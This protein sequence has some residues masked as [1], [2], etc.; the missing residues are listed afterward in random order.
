M[1]EIK[2]ISVIGAGQMGSGIAQAAAQAGYEVNLRDVD[3]KY[4]QQAFAVMRKSLELMSSKGKI[5]VEEADR[6]IS[7]IKSTTDEGCKDPSRL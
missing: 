7:R 5:S 4:L 1:S 6:V 2:T 3:E